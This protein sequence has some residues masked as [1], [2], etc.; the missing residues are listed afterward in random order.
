MAVYEYKCENCGATFEV[1]R[2]MTDEVK[3]EEEKVECTICGSSGTHRIYSSVS[4][5]CSSGCSTAMSNAY[6]PRFYGG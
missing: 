5:G 2:N 4:K 6:R 3:N 1:Y